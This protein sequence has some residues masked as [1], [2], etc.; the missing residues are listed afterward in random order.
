M[1]ILS[2]LLKKSPVGIGIRFIK[3]IKIIKFFIT[4]SCL[5]VF[6]INKILTVFLKNNKKVDTRMR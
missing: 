3:I 5:I 2:Q 6:L 1:I 4:S